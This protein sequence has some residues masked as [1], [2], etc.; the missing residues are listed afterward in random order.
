MLELDLATIVFEV[1]NFL[2]L[3]AL[4]YR[5]LLQPVLRRVQERAA[6]KERLMSEI[7]REREEVA[8]LRAD[9]EERLS[10][11]EAEAA[12]IISQA[13]E[14]ARQQSVALRQKSN[15]EAERILEQAQ[16]EAARWRQQAVAEFHNELLDTILDVSA[17]VMAQTAPPSLHDALVQQLCDRIWHMGSQE[18]Q[19]VETIRRSLRDREPTVYVTTARPLTTAQQGQLVRTFTALVDRNVS[20]EVNRDDDLVA[21]L[22][23]RLGDLIV[24]N[25]IIEQVAALREQVAERL[26]QYGSVEKV[27]MGAIGHG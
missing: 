27:A 22:R 25:S 1:I 15:A 14:K 4:L 26:N 19:H 12:E 17:Q 21:G 2:L 13:E 23:V 5:F 6:E 24:E 7:A 20:L 9:W 3:S 16:L 10:R 8:A 11:V 18:M